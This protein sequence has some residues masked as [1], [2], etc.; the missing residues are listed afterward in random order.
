MVL[1]SFKKYFL[2]KSNSYQYYKKKA[3]EN[4]NKINELNNSCQDYKKKAEENQNKINE[5]NNSCQDYKKKAEE[6]QNKINE[7]NSSCQDY[8]KKTEKYENRINELNKNINQIENNEILLRNFSKKLDSLDVIE[9]LLTIGNTYNHDDY[10]S[11]KKSGLFNEKWYLKKYP[12]VMYKNIDPITHH[13]LTWKTLAT[14]PSP[15]F[16]TESYLNYHEDVQR[17]GMN[18]FVH[19]IKYGKNENRRIFPSG[20]IY[21]PDKKSNKLDQIILQENV[22][23]IQEKK[24]RGFKINVVFITYSNIW[25]SDILYH[26]LDEDDNFNVMIIVVPYMS[27]LPSDSEI[28]SYNETYE[29]FKKEGYNVIKGYDE[30][31]EKTID[32]ELECSPDIIFYSSNW[33]NVYPEELQFDFIPRSTLL[34]Y[35]P[36]GISTGNIFK[37]HINSEMY[38]KSWKV[39]CETDF[40]KKTI[41]QQ[42]NRNFDPGKFIVSGFPKLDG[43]FLDKYYNN[44]WKWKRTPI[45][46]SKRNK[47]YKKRIIWAPHWTF[48]KNIINFSTFRENYKF[49]YDYAKNNMNIEWIFRPHPLLKESI[50][51]H[52]IMSE[53]KVEKYYDGWKNLENT[54]I[55][56]GGDYTALYTY[57]D[58]MITDSVSFIAEYLF[59]NKPGLR[60]TNNTQNFNSFGTEAA[61]MWYDCKGFQI[62]K[63]EE[64][65]NEVVINEND[66]KKEERTKFIEKELIP[67]GNLT[68]SENIYKYLQNTFTNNKKT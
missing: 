20:T 10:V 15:S 9:E 66:T 24:K 18:P 55:Y 57:S 11:I 12:Y 5:L 16:S 46:F 53:K 59:C 67:K 37:D 35:I 50:V 47:K 58:A 6:N 25:T 23:N 17:S 32:I 30:D 27:N 3:E 8:K 13:L 64:F 40:H 19:Y 56:E 65:I 44:T 48:D 54:Q 21:N 33:M 52:N 26:F 68:A 22:R 60:L 43:L 4:Q 45:N 2:E 34:C 62:N 7:L 61:Q 41:I 14:D 29:R 63:I 42:N 49:F 31:R 28:K 36:Y 51:S 38:E 1:N 39:F